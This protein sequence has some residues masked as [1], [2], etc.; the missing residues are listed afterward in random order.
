M[1][2]E[3]GPASPASLAEAVGNRAFA[4]A[5]AA[6]RIGAAG[7]LQRYEAPAEVTAVPVKQKAYYRIREAVA[8]LDRIVP[9]LSYKPPAYDTAK[10]IVQSV[11]KS[12]DDWLGDLLNPNRLMKVFGTMWTGAHRICWGARNAIGEM[13]GGLHRAQ[14][15][16]QLRGETGPKP[17]LPDVQLAEVKFAVPYVGKLETRSRASSRARRTCPTSRPGS[18]SSPAP[19]RTCSRG[20]T[21]T[22]RRSPR[23][24]RSS[25]STVARSPA[26]SRGRRS[27]R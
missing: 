3:A 1:A 9:M 18:P 23:R 8:D 26:R 7:L 20:S 17:S 4:S 27:S 25:G 16:A 15:D 14:H 11:Y 21:S 22:G 12:V 6:G 24:L 19:R 2:V 13:F 5:V 10:I